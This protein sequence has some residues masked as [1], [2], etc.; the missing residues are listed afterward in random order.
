MKSERLPSK[1]P[2]AATPSPPVSRPFCERR[3]NALQKA[4]FYNAKG[5]I[6]HNERPYF[7]TQQIF[8][9]KKPRHKRLFIIFAHSSIII[10][11]LRS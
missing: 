11:T 5:R 1:K 4:V 3:Q 8:N 10:K 6:L 2:P 7:A 9:G